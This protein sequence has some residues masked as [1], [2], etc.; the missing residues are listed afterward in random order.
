VIALVLGSSASQLTL[1]G[2][3]KAPAMGHPDRTG[4]PDGL[5]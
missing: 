3:A 2:D 4:L 5:A 1:A